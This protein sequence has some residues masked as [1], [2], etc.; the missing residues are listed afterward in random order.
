M[1]MAMVLTIVIIVSEGMSQ[2]LSSNQLDLT[3]APITVLS[4]PNYLFNAVLP[5]PDWLA[6]PS[7]GS[8]RSFSH[9]GS[10]EST[11]RL[12]AAYITAGKVKLSEDPHPSLPL[13]P[14]TQTQTT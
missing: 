6:A 7:G 10:S 12:H 14:H 2:S 1:M 8:H 11:G 3:R 13:H 9:H 4:V 5:G